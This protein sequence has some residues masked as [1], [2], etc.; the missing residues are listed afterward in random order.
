MHTHPNVEGFKLTVKINYQIAKYIS[1][2]SKG[3]ETL[4][5]KWTKNIPF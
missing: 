5:K 4:Y 2:K 1:S 3:L